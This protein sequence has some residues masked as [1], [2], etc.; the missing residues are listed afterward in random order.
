MCFWLVENEC[1]FHATQVQLYNGG[2]LQK[3]CAH[4]KFCVFWL[5]VM[6]FSVTK[7]KSQKEIKCEDIFHKVYGYCQVGWEVKGLKVTPSWI[8]T[9]HAMHHWQFIYMQLD[10]QAVA[11]SFTKK[12]NKKTKNK[13][14]NKKN[15]NESARVRMINFKEQVASHSLA[16]EGEWCNLC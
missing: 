8:G 7:S 5:S 2:K 15:K 4:S 14:K 6:L 12:K 16:K 13:K 10:P 9:F 3:A 1:I 11:H